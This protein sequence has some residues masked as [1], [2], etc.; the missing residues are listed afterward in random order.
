MY[1]KVRG[2]DLGRVG[3]GGWEEGSR[4]GLSSRAPF[5]QS[6]RL[7]G[8][9][10]RLGVCRAPVRLPLVGHRSTPPTLPLPCGLVFLPVLFVPGLP[11]FPACPGSWPSSQA[12]WVPRMSRGGTAH[13][14]PTTPTLPYIPHSRF[15][16]HPPSSSLLSLCRNLRQVP[17]IFHFSSLLFVP[18]S[19]ISLSLSPSSLGHPCSVLCTFLLL[20]F[21]PDIPS[22]IPK[23]Y[24][25][26]CLSV[27]VRACVSVFVVAQVCLLLTA[28]TIPIPS[29]LLSLTPPK[30]FHFSLPAIPI[31]PFSSS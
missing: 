10:F 15:L 20:L 25:P 21:L 30:F 19:D 12:I 3:G 8:P 16:C 2:M 23:L 11:V 6:V 22:Q 13:W 31:S 18:S 17:C 29:H 26:C 7:A 4:V 24:A 5:R 14:F 9:P 1:I 28:G 27:C